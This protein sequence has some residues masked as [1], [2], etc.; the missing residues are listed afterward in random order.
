VQTAASLIII[1]F[2]Y[3]LARLL[4]V[5]V[6]IAFIASFPAISFSGSWSALGAGVDGTV[7][8]LAV[9]PDGTLYAGGQF[10]TAGGV[11]VN[12]IAKWNGSTWS[13]LG[14]GVD[15]YVH[16]L[17]VGQDGTLYAGGYFTTAGGVSVNNIA[18][19][20]GS[21]WSALG[22]GVNDFVS[23]LGVG[24]DGSLYAGGYLTTAGGVSVNNIAKWNGSAWSALG[25]GFDGYVHS[26]TVAPD[27]TLYAGGYF[28]T[29]GGVSANKIAKWN[30]STWS[31]LGDG[32]DTCPTKVVAGPDGTLYAVA[33]LWLGNESSQTNISKWDGSV[34][35]HHTMNVTISQSFFGTP[36]LDLAV[37]TAGYLY[38]GGFFAT[39]DGN[40]I[41]FL[42]EWDGSAW[43]GLSNGVD[44]PVHTLASGQNDVLY[45]GGQFTTAGGVT[46]NGIASWT[47]GPITISAPSTM[48]TVSGPVTFTT[49]YSGVDT[50]SLSP[51]DIALNRTGT[52]D[53]TIAV[54]GSG[55][56]RDVIIS[57]ITGEGTLGISISAGTALDKYGNSAPAA[58][59]S[60]A[61]SVG[62]NAQTVTIG[63]P[64]AT[65][66]RSD[67]VTYTVTYS[68]SENISLAADDITLNKSGTAKG[69]VTVS[70]TGDT[71]TVTISD[72][73]G[74]GTLGISI[75]AGTAS[76]EYGRPAPA[77]G[78]SAT[79]KVD[80]TTPTILI[81]SPSVTS[82]TSGPV[83]YSV[84]YSGADTVSLSSSDITL[85]S[86]DTATGT[87][88]V[89]GSGTSRVVVISNISGNGT[90]GISI[91]AGTAS[92]QAGNNA[93]AAG[94][95]AIFY[96]NDR[97]LSYEMH[98]VG[99]APTAVAIGD[100]NGDGRNDVV[101]TTSFD[102]DDENDY[103]VF[104]FLQDENG[105]LMSPVRYK[106]QGTY[107]NRP[108][109]V[110][111]AKLEGS[112]TNKVIV[113]LWGKG[114]EIFDTNKN[115]ELTG[116]TLIS[117]TY[118]GVIKVA[119][120]NND[121]LNDIIGMSGGTVEVYYQKAGGGF[122]SP[123]RYTT[124][125]GGALCDLAVGDINGD[126]FDDIVVTD[127]S[128][129][130]TGLGIL[131]QKSSGGFEAPAYY[132]ISMPQGVAIGDFNEDGRNDVVATSGPTSDS[133]ISVFFQ[134]SIG[135][136]DSAAKYTSYNYPETVR[137]VK[138]N[139][140]KTDIAVLHS[141]GTLGIYE[142]K[143]DKTL[144][145][146]A[147]VPLPYATHYLPGGMA[148]G[149]I[150]GDGKNDIVIAD[151]NNGLV[152]VYQAPS[153]A[154][155]P[156]IWMSEPSAKSTTSEPVTY[157]IVYS[158]ADTISLSQS[159]ITLDKNGTARGTVAVSGTGN[160]RT[161]TISDITGDGMLGISIA[162][163]TASDQAGNSAPAAGPST[164]FQVGDNTQT[165]SIGPPSS[166]VT[167]AGP[168]IYT[169][170]YSGSD[171]I[172]LA[173]S[174]IT[175]NKTGTAKGTVS[176]SGS[177]NTRI[178]TISG[179]SGDGTLGI[180]IDAG[181]AKDRY[182]RRSLAAGSS[183]NFT[184]DNT[185][186]CM[187]I[188]SPS[189]SSTQSGPVTYSVT[190]SGADTI[191]LSP[192]DIT[193]NKTGTADGKVAVS[194][195]G[196]TRTVT[197][198]SISG[199]GTLGISIAGGTAS[200]QAGNTACAAG[201]SFTFYVHDSFL[202]SEYHYVGS[203]PQAVA[204]GDVNGDGRNDVVLAT[205]YYFDDEND[206]CL[207]VFLQDENGNLMSPIKYKTQGD[208]SHSPYSIAIAKI[209]G[210]DTNK[211]IVGLRGKGIEIFDT[212][213][214]GELTGSTL[215][216]TTN[217]YAIKVADINNDGLNDIVG[218]GYGTNSVDII[219]Q[220][221]GGGFDSPVSYSINQTG[222]PDFA[223]GDVNGDGLKD[224]AFMT[225]NSSSG[226]LGILHQKSSGGFDSPV[227]YQVSFPGGIAIGDFNSDGLND[228]VI[229]HG[230]N[231]GDAKISVFIQNSS[232]LNSAVEYISD[233][234]PRTVR[235]ASV[236]GNKTDIV[237]LHQAWSA[238]GIY[239]QKDDKTLSP[240]C[241]MPVQS[242][243]SDGPDSMA[244]GD[245]NGDGKN[246][247]VFADYEG[248]LIVVYHAPPKASEATLSVS[249]PSVT[250]T[251]SGPVTYTVTYSGAD[252]I[253]LAA[254]DITLNKTGSADGSVSVSGNG[255]TRTV[256]VSN[257]SGNGS[258]GINVGARTA[259]D[260][261]GNG[262]SAAGPSSTFAV[263]NTAPSLTIGSPSTSLSSTDIV[264]FI[265][266]Y[267]GADT[268]S[269]AP[270]DITLIA[271]G[272]ARGSAAVIGSG[273]TRIVTISNII[274]DGTL[275]ISIA[276]GTATD[277]AGN[278]AP[279]AGPSTSF[280]V[281]N[282]G[283]CLT[284]GSPSSSTTRSGPLTYTVTYSGADSVSLDGSNITL[285][286]TGNAD[287]IISVTGS[288]NTTRMVIISSITGDG[289]L[290]ISISSDTAWDNAGN[291][292]PSAG[293]ST[294][295]TVDNISPTISIG[296]P[297]ATSTKSGPITFAVTY[298][299]ADTISLAAADITLNKTG[300]ANGSLAVSGTGNTR[301]VNVSSI[302]G[303]G[304]LGISI[305]AGT[306]TD[307]AGNSA[308]AA[309]P[310]TIFSVANSTPGVS[311]SAPSATI[312]NSSSNISYTISYSSAD[313]ITL[314]PGNITLNKTG[315][316]NGSISVSGSGSASRTVTLSG[317]T[318][319]G[320]LGIS[321]G[322]GT[323]S[324]P[325]GSSTSAGPSS[326]FKVDNTAPTVSI[327]NPSVISTGSGPV[328]Y[329]VT[330]GGADSIT[331]ST[332]NVT[333][334]RTGTASGTVAVSGSG[335]SRTVTISSITGAG[336]LGISI[337]AGTASDT[338]GN[339]APAAGPST[340]FTADNTPPSLLINSHTGNQ[341]VSMSTI[342]LSG[343][344]SDSGKGNSG[345]QR[346][347]VNGTRANN[348][349]ASGSGTARW[350]IPVTLNY[351]SNTITVVAYD[352][353][354]NNNSTSQNITLYYPGDDNA[355][356]FLLL[357]DK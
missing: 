157:T 80:N 222:W 282:T 311:I 161:I 77:A 205:S 338:A 79:F 339:S 186:P 310:S 45:V 355:V 302:T 34:W 165:L 334:N 148:V 27:G 214:S 96:V 325:A 47:P 66:I 299:G 173:Q 138:I 164:T 88:D 315:T 83:L 294:A 48:S 341:H 301:T 119:D 10:T 86:T 24:T 54:S 353:S 346:V 113:G 229:A 52:A 26:L 217:S 61:F 25:T 185:Q 316:A 343:T 324:N 16:S 271:T 71:R 357:L 331:L 265:V 170:T 344:A 254:A 194:G 169:V 187:C 195:S 58:G 183:S 210:S 248:S 126:G 100:V 4:F 320:T 281:D 298:G 12:N 144:S 356:Y 139:G 149:D 293:P 200:D 275:A 257:I 261:A 245:I 102:F 283:P 150:N 162:A 115:G 42:A 151:Y 348:D 178:V 206:F 134:N 289:T 166:T 223:I 142:L 350:S 93:P 224:I 116:S 30:G 303:D 122:M 181:T 192:S 304:T 78:A 63:S 56:V 287:G 98:S 318:G 143:A 190:Y 327:G 184:V 260:Q 145:F 267:S 104:V 129:A 59:P 240:E 234:I 336:T 297:S 317:T 269:L 264:S 121:G 9:A 110:A 84:T 153:K 352:D 11:N 81:G 6:V 118:S 123:V 308:P 108:N 135:A 256:T 253:S 117:T 220:K 255:N 182:G 284:I 69:T 212:N 17:A 211:V 38:A 285:N 41:S 326:T 18:K 21:A 219:Y 154:A 272:S 156:T 313:S 273:N 354:S 14:A 332:A 262:A 99:P 342:T 107:T 340:T 208:Y 15:G 112:T 60:T 251:I 68:G 270:S 263:D 216:S 176:V 227:Y 274:G 28:T 105:I 159:D 167:A 193:I 20:N 291:S 160:A 146:G 231:N 221:P 37:G 50:I 133:T 175:L 55:N 57:E 188:G 51:A 23:S 29:A 228:V 238:I 32:L 36:V 62:N 73:S 137:A 333:L 92:D 319:D 168:V 306:A 124:T 349:T 140:N 1:R 64:S 152:V 172:S 131:R 277:K 278:G 242:A 290:G 35:F 127:G 307:S 109:S 158:E 155:G 90:L 201:P 85:N 33:N 241:L 2:P 347:I 292:A 279:A 203:S 249:D 13:A 207:F 132:Q 335:N 180:S 103:C 44:N 237:V 235:A 53:G 266:T 128:V 94:P 197:I 295:F 174:D 67:P 43:S 328:T 202:S 312:A 163:G 215:I 230:G 252:T 136:L 286:K 258:L 120:V 321:I 87:I 209:D 82:T 276:A 233:G 329:T 226:S 111:I 89:A 246:D 19:W 8:S 189:I 114:I 199:I 31:A 268:I 46:V 3:L 95:S 204:I 177:G 330:Y 345:I 106:T 300:T 288:G 141:G 70:G 22:T 247:I 280:T 323:A 125:H 232:A 101:L 191:S 7:Y 72:I 49:R 322:A 74:T 351:G 91:A 337:S 305:A 225:R 218:I 171:T 76:D 296:N 40:D 213:S 196:N 239:E 39:I 179:I 130:T 236:I 243:S 314:S 147:L 75:A 198:F 244:V 97:F 5:T 65:I 309:G 250:S 259:F